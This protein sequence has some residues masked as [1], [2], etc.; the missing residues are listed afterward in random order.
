MRKRG[1]GLLLA[2]C[3]EK[4]LPLLAAM[5]QMLGEDEQA[6]N[7]KS[8]QELQEMLA[9]LLWEGHRAFTFAEEGRV[10]GYAL[11]NMQKKPIYLRHFFICREARRK[12]CG[13]RAFHAL[14]AGLG[15]RELDLDA[16]V[17]NERGL[18]F[19]ESLGFCKRCYMMRYAPIQ[20]EGNGGDGH[21]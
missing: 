15:A 8:L 6:D 18:A 5:A 4:D 12:G 10:V 11:C 21:A 17:W 13:T 7:P 2:E 14:V 3:S 1:G 16:Y 20:P 19:W 9:A